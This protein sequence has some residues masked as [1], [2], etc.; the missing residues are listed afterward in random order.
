GC[1]IGA[2]IGDNLPTAILQLI[3][4]LFAIFI[5]IYFYRQKN[6]FDRNYSMPDKGKLNCIALGIGAASNL[7]GI[8]GGSMSVPFFLTVQIPMKKAIATS[9]GTGAIITFV[10]AVSYLYFGLDE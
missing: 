4:G 7:L 5:G 2:F 8:G 9:A 10:G 1:I 6:L 3:F